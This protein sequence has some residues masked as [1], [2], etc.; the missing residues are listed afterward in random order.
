MLLFAN[1]SMFQALKRTVKDTK[2][3][4]LLL[5]SSRRELEFFI[6][7][8]HLDDSQHK[9]RDFGDCSVLVHISHF[10]GRNSPNESIQCCI[11]W[12]GYNINTNYFYVRRYVH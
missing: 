5:K 10:P 1:R 9:N 8:D 6:F 3:S 7:F 12:A 2:I 11:D 4:L